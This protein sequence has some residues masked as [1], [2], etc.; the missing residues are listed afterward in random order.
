MKLTSLLG[1]YR[2][3][4]SDPDRAPPPLPMNPGSS[5]ATKPNTSASITA[6]AEALTAK[7]RESAYTTNPLPNRSPERSLIKGQ[8][9][10]RMQS[11]QNG[12]GNVRDRNN[13]LDGASSV[14][15][16]PERLPRTTAFDFENRSPERSPTRT[17]TP[18]PNAKEFA[19]DTPILRPSSRPPLKAILGENTP[20]SSTMLAL[21]NI[22][23]LKEVDTSL[24]N[25]TNGASAMM[26]TPQTF[27]AISSQILSLT[28]IA[29]N[30][31]REM[32]QLSR[33]SKDNATD[34]ISLKEATNLRDEDIRTSLRDLV[35]NLSS[36]LIEP[37]VDNSSRSTSHYGRGPGGFLID[38]KP[39]V[40]PSGMPKSFSLPRIPSPNSF[41]ASLD[42]EIVASP[43]NM[44]GAASIALLEKILREMGT[45]E[46]Q[47]R[48][49]SS[50]SELLD[51]SKSRDSDPAV[52]K[53]LEEILAFLKEGNEK[54]LVTQTNDGNEIGDIPPKLEL[55]FDPR[56]MSLARISRGT[57]P[58]ASREMNVEGKI[59]HANPGAAAGFVSE[60]ILKMLRKMKD[61][62]T[63]GGGMTAELK[64]LVREL[65]GEVLGMG[66][67]IGRKLDQAE[68]IQG[69]QAD[70]Q[71]PSRDEIAQIVEQGL[72]ELKDH[73]ENSMREMRRQSSS[74]II[75]RSTVDSQE[76][77]TAV[78]NALSESPFHQ[79]IAMQHSGSG[80]EREEILE[81]VREAWETYKPEIELQNFGLERDE[82]LQ[83]L[84][85]GLQEYQPKEQNKDLGGASYEEV[86]DAVQ[87]G[88]K[89][90]KPPPPIE[91]EASITKEEILM[92]VRECLD[93]FEFP[94]SSVGAPRELEMTR[95]DV[96]DAVKEGFSTQGPLVKEIDFNRDDIFEAVRAGLE[97]ARTPMDGVGEQ[98]LEKMQDLI[99][100]MRVEFKQ[101]SVA[102]G[103]DTEQVLDAM[104]DGLEVLRADIE[105]YVDRA[106]DVTGKD[107]IIETVRDGLEHLRVDLEGAIA[108]SPRESGNSNNGE[109]LDAMEKEFE[110]LRQT[111]ATSMVR[112][113]EPTTDREEIL[114]TIRDGLEDLKRN[115]P[116]E[117][118]RDVNADAMKDEFEHL[119]Q[120]IAMSIVPSGGL[121]IDREEI[122]Y[123]IRD[124][125]E[126]LKRNMPQESDRAVNA[127]TMK[128]EFEHL[129]QT[130]ATSM[131]RSEEPAIDREEMLDAI[132]DG[133]KDLKRN[134]L[135]EN[136]RD[137][138]SNIMEKEFELLRQTIATSIVPSGASTIDKQE[139]LN[140]I[141]DGLEALKKNLAQ[142][143]NRDVNAE[144]I[145]TV[146]EELEH[147]RETLS[148]TL[149]RGSCS[150]DKEELLEA[151]RD[152]LESVRLDIERNRDKPESVSSIS[153]EV[154][155]A[156]NDGLDGLRAD[157]ERMVNKPLDMT[158][159]YEILDTLKEGLANIRSDVD[160]LRSA[161]QE[162]TTSKGGEVIVADGEAESLRRN[163]IENLEVMITQLRIK[164]ESMDTPPVPP[165]AQ[166]APPNNDGALVKEDLENIEGILRDVQVTIAELTQRNQIQQDDT[167]TKED[168]EAIETL[169]RNTKARID[170]MLSA[171]SEGLAR[172]AQI[173]N[174]EAITR[175]TLDAVND[176]GTGKASKE[177]VGILEALLKEIFVGVEDVREKILAQ[178]IDDRVR[179][180]DFENLETVCLD[181]KTHI[182]DIVLPGI[183]MMPT[184]AEIELLG[185]LIKD[186]R[187]R[188]EEDA[189]LTAR[190]FESRK[191]EHG[192]IADKIEDVKLFLDDVRAELKGKLDKDGHSIRELTTTLETFTDTVVGS[193]VTPLVNELKEMLIR[194]FESI[195]GDFAGSELE[196]EQHHSSLLEKH[197]EYK[198][199]IITELLSKIEERFDEILTKYDDAQVAAAE[200]DRASKETSLE[201]TDI[202]NATKFATEDLKAVLDTLSSTLTESCERLG[203]DSKTVFERI[204]G[205]SSKLD[206]LLSQ[207]VKSE[208]QSTRAEIS[209]TLTGVEGVQAHVTQYQPKILET[210]QEVLGIVEQHYEQAKSSA[211]EIKS[212]VQ[213]IPA[214][215]PL[216]AIAAPPPTPIEFPVHEPYN[217]SAVHAK[218]DQLVEHAGEANK[219]LTQF[220]LLDHIR[221]QVSATAK[222]LENLVAG[223]QAM[224]RQE[225]NDRAK[226]AEEVGV[227]LKLRIS[228]KEHVEADIVRMMAHK[229]E[230]NKD[231]QELVL[232]K[233]D[234]IAQRSKMQADLS[235]LHTALQIR[236][237]EL[238]IM[239]TRAEGLERRILDGVLDHSRSLLTASR[240]RS[241]LKEMN[242][243][244]VVSTASNNTSSTRTSIGGPIAP[245][246]ATSAVSSGIGMALK[247]RQPIRKPGSSTVSGKG[248]RRIL[249][250]ST[251]GANRGVNAERSMVLAN[252]SHA[253]SLTKGSAFGIGGVKRSHS[254][255]SNFPVRKASWGGTKAL[256][257]YADEG[258]DDEDDKENSILDEEDEEEDREGSE[259]G[260]ERRT[261][262]SGT[263]TGTMSYGDG[264]VVSADDRR[265]SY[266]PSTVESLGTKDDPMTEDGDVSDSEFID[267]D[268]DVEEVEH[269]RESTPMLYENSSVRGGEIG[270]ANEMVLFGETSDSGIGTEMP[271]AALEG[272]SD[273]FGK[274]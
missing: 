273:Y 4:S 110:H 257:M 217:D 267:D 166:P 28:S 206:E 136:D 36:H 183:E 177:D 97:G 137:V 216:P 128:D 173:E 142:E 106:A 30:L 254:V 172:V 21:Q 168:T 241:S 71:G 58:H 203:E 271:T 192:G 102:N 70:Y 261:S 213:A 83:C 38:S 11:L 103:G 150:A 16:S 268:D 86:L 87:E 248:D 244:R 153:G 39:H 159:N 170:D 104:K 193:D 187:E 2:W 75:S 120:T 41:S 60:D 169:L 69:Q 6:A 109:I 111:I 212:S 19:R 195:H 79:Q 226:E 235:S 134:M 23:A 227:A 65:R 274:E 40:S 161:E 211:E 199:A 167:V 207:D 146:K 158:V 73:M 82:I 98:V 160:R 50:L 256:G 238:H 62:I 48:L 118:D 126:D 63:E 64:A 113:G 155:D 133:L 74:S 112:S 196:R 140:T 143:G 157:V 239:E 180:S 194:E 18:T 205:M 250:L 59:L 263:Y 132:R 85:E 124:G 233:E 49:L 179:K 131:I 252:A 270:N 240:P 247:R 42:R 221:E 88:L 151:L 119:R 220:A 259:T 188:R 234:L 12:H 202:L 249:S 99:D 116:Q 57:N 114:D 91:T 228:Q 222:E 45:K 258:V 175:E 94:T 201:Q 68:S 184:K 260:T 5:P 269:E 123:A 264:S 185:D 53:K 200:H 89:H 197:D 121:T 174:V 171:E 215:I 130:I 230:L 67:E 162:I 266:A 90:F 253:D 25:I 229:D 242:L 44:D 144:A 224:I 100:G 223:Q 1:K 24:S 246:Y 20:P 219:S 176:I 92:T 15:R 95:E 178:D 84:K 37:G 66:R 243:K 272:G 225:A 13:Y 231:V 101:Y 210:I 218:L 236:R 105:T 181:T 265:T 96:I 29:T 22:P 262:Y 52:A 55:E 208:H 93:T 56:S 80:I 149:V 26:R 191:I 148:T 7:A 122:L 115:M 125:L 46:G 152:G 135:Q 117:S 186:F 139:I 189:E 77:Y 164:V 255:K 9:H 61:S 33:R 145:I 147:L 245:S 34:L 251:L 54:V 129:R 127:D 154:V 81:A 10:K 108:N 141:R 204:G 27:E 3:D 182:E 43:Y 163:D 156:L 32:A 209:K 138:N 17:G 165:V 190:A 31:Q 78:K 214:A 47:E 237:E 232:V 107:E 76:I 72:A 8:Y 198:T 51:R 14:E 35:T